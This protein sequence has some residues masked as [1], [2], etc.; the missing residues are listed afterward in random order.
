MPLPPEGVMDDEADMHDFLLGQD[1]VQ[2]WD[3]V[4]MEGLFK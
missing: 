2:V 1:I 4:S 3:V